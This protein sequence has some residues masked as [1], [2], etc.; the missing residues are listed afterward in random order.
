[1]KDN[2]KQDYY[3]IRSQ[4][5]NDNGIADLYNVIVRDYSYLVYVKISNEFKIGLEIQKWN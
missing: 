3:D 5:L 2:I 1:M 4:A